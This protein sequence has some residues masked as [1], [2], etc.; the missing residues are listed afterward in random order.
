ML[1]VLFTVVT[2]QQRYNIGD[3][4]GRNTHQEEGNEEGRAALTRRGVRL[5]VS[6]SITSQETEQKLDKAESL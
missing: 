6:K 2:Q 1:F 5:K 4:K 3:L